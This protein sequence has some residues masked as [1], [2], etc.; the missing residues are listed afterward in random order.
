[1]DNF[2][3]FITNPDWWSVM[4]SAISAI[5]VIVIAVV[6]IR[7]QRRQIKTAE[8]ETYRQLYKFIYKLDNEIDSFVLNVCSILW[9]SNQGRNFIKQRKESV[10]NLRKELSQNIIDF[11]LKFSRKFFDDCLYQNILGIMIHSWNSVDE[12][13]KNDEL[14]FEQCM[15]RLYYED[16]YGDAEYAQDFVN[17]IKNQE[18]KDIYTL[19]FSGFLSHKQQIY[20]DAIFKRIKERCKI[21]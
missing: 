11:D 13:V 19:L 7:L 17:H 20:D 16:E 10:N 1:M 6:Q 5:A 12:M 3:D 14:R 21:D 15:P 9:E 8:F 2:C 4:F 18:L